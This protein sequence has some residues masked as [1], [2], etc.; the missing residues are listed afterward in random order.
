MLTS[1]YGRH[2]PCRWLIMRQLLEE[3]TS[4]SA[5]HFN[6]CLQWVIFSIDT[7]DGQVHQNKKF[8]DKSASNWYH[9]LSRRRLMKADCVTT[10]KND[11]LG[12]WEN[13]IFAQKFL[14]MH[15]WSIRGISDNIL[16]SKFLVA[17]GTMLH[18]ILVHSI[19]YKS[20]DYTNSYN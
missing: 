20:G 16:T 3:P 7:L 10:N 19:T 14:K 13:T 4:G 8:T 15:N 9:F 12:C 6:C 17:W 11:W 2:P 5:I 1:I 18:V